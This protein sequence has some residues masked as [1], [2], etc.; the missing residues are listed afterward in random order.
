MK[1][2]R[3]FLTVVCHSVM[4]SM[5]DAFEAI[6]IGAIFDHDSKQ[7]HAAFRFAI[8][9]QNNQS[10][11]RF[12]I[13]ASAVECV[14]ITD[15]FILSSEICSQMSR[16]MFALFGVNN[17][18]SVNTVLSYA[19]TFHMPFI[20][21]NMVDDTNLKTDTDFSWVFHMMPSYTK[22]MVDIIQAKG[23]ETF[24]Y[25]YDSDEALI[26]IQ[27][28]NKAL[29]EKNM[30]VKM[31]LRRIP[32][33]QNA[34]GF[35]RHIARAKKPEEKRIILDIAK[36]K[37]L[38][39]FLAQIEEVKMAKRKYH[40]LIAGLGMRELNLNDFTTKGVNITGFQLLDKDDTAV[41]NFVKAW[42]ALDKVSWPGTEEDPDHKAAL[43]Y[44]GVMVFKRAISDMLKE[45]ARV[46]QNVFRGK[47]Q[48]YNNGSKGLNCKSSPPIPWSFG[49]QVARALNRA[50]D[51]GVTGKIAFDRYGRRR[52]Y[53]ISVLEQGFKRNIVPVGEW[54]DTRGLVM[55]PPT[56]VNEKGKGEFD[57]RTRTVTSILVDPFLMR[58]K[59][60]RED[61]KPL[62]F[63]DQFEGYC[64]DLSNKMAKRVGF[65]FLIRAV[66]DGSYGGYDK[67]NDT[68]N[69]MIGELVRGEADL[70]VAPLTI[71]AAR[72]KVVDFSKPF[73]SLGI[74]IMI[75]K[76]E[77]RTP[78][79]FSFMDPL[80]SEIW[81]CIG[82]A[83]IGVSVVLFLVSRFSPYE[84]HIEEVSS[85][86]T[87][88]N[89]FT[90]FNS[91]WFILAAFMQ[92]GCEISPRSMS[93]RIVGSVWW[94]FTF[95]IISSYTANLAAFLTVERMSAP[96]SGADDLAKQTEIK[97]GMVAS[98]STQE[99]FK[100]SQLPTYQRM[101]TFMKSNAE[102]V[103]PPTT[104]AGVEK[105][106]DSNGKYAFLLESTMNEYM[107]QQE[108]CTTMRV[109]SN[110]DSKGYGVATPFHSDLRDHVTLA[111]LEAKENGDLHKLEQKW[112]YERSLC[113]LGKGSTKDALQNALDLNNVAGIFLILISGLISSLFTSILELLYRAK[114]DSKRKKIPF[115]AS[116][117]S[118]T[119]IT[120]HGEADSS[121]T[122][123]L[124][125]ELAAHH[126]HQYKPMSTV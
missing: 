76:P 72:E 96:I 22:A 88:K 105:V 77:K 48:V 95:I 121:S 102:E 2:I 120:I 50:E 92:Q 46:F 30:Q 104:Q 65:T 63:N 103:F 59:K 119:Y 21:P 14:D 36:M 15:S 106:R 116:L 44:D 118:K 47:G 83:Y 126:H 40:Y 71:T 52:D 38:Q 99:F 19:N 112:W 75:K 107:N 34:L 110:L 33:V 32:D 109:G 10:R 90:I 81:M 125:A 25:L 41:Q 91:L 27:Q 70:A 84:W 58:L 113:D 57:N 93:G 64:L 8:M 37:D 23:W 18:S 3:I 39:G 117:R 26:R 98:G 115:L 61:G 80:S 114:V 17:V 94:F 100:T 42:N 28:I 12:R 87:A 11:P 29:N 89:D 69:G 85:N 45:N 67:V 62:V 1:E 5:A 6:P 49:V 79:V 68:W 111:V 35:L 78:S 16:G 56:I 60:P 108:P 86:P 74:S 31:D 54:S 82:F 9:K 20:T 97:Y 124:E 66:K 55:N 13:D 122:D 24:Y 4:M 7:I 101:W 53:K 123:P 51:Q 43:A 73:M